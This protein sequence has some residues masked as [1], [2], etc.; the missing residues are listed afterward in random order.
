MSA[1]ADL[2]LALAIAVAPAAQD[3]APLL[4]TLNANPAQ[5]VVVARNI[6]RDVVPGRVRPRPIPV[7]GV[8]TRWSCGRPPSAG[9]RTLACRIDAP[10]LVVVYRVR[11]RVG[12][13]SV[14]ARADR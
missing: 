4:P 1:L 12:R 8:L 11:D 2:A 5:T 3:R 6:T 9:P 10:G 13:V 7:R 14:V